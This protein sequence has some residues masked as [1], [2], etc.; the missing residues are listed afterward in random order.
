MQLFNTALGACRSWIKHEAKTISTF[1]DIF[2]KVL[3]RM[4]SKKPINAFEG[5]RHRH[6][7]MLGT[8][9][10]NMGVCL[11]GT[12]RDRV[13][14]RLQHSPDE[15]RDAKF[16][17]ST[18]GSSVVRS[19]LLTPLLHARAS[20][21]SPSAPFD[22]PTCWT[23]NKK[24]RCFSCLTPLRRINTTVSFIVNNLSLLQEEN[25]VHPKGKP[26][27]YFQLSLQRGCLCR[28]EGHSFS[29]TM[30]SVR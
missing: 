9:T 5:L 30:E 1:F 29:G 14:V 15:I 2:V 21:S 4:G 11:S 7:I 19:L 3:Q 17:T 28:Q 23:T 12:D 24:I 6:D 20:M 18:D 26:H 8:R 22:F 25:N 13:L 10:L 16:R 27:R